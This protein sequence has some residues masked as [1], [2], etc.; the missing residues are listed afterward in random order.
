MHPCGSAD[1]GS[2]VDVGTS[3]SRSTLQAITGVAYAVDF[4]DGGLVRSCLDY[5][6]MSSEAVQ[7]LKFNGLA[8]GV[9]L[10]F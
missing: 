1:I 6:L 5:R 7:S 8:L 2:Q 10:R 3:E 4:G 9:A